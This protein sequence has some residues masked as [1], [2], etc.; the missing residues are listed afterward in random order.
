MSQSANIPPAPNADPAIH[1]A[2][3][4]AETWSRTKKPQTSIPSATTI[5]AKQSR[6]LS[7]NRQRPER[8]FFIRYSVGLRSSAISYP[9]NRPT[10]RS[11]CTT[12]TTVDAI[13]VRE[14]GMQASARPMLRIDRAWNTR[15]PAQEASLQALHQRGFHYLSPD[16]ARRRFGPLGSCNRRGWTCR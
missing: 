6:G 4:S 15:S 12:Q 11:S 9:N 10:G 8:G 1:K 16:R 7:R 3:A 13:Q 2:S 5:M 14:T